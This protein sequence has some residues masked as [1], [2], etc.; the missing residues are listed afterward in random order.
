MAAA[1]ERGRRAR[2]RAGKT[3]K[4]SLRQAKV[5]ASNVK[6]AAAPQVESLASRA[7]DAAVSVKD[8][9]AP[10]VESLASRAADAIEH[11]TAHDS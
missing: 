9:A 5:T 7:K 10:Q 8:A 2:R 4:R 3:A 11:L 6:D 1:A